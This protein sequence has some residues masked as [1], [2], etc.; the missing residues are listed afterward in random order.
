MTEESLKS[1]VQHFVP[2]DEVCVCVC[3]CVCDPIRVLECA[4][5]FVM[6]RD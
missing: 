1:F 4:C 2:E 6:P 3:V 5:E